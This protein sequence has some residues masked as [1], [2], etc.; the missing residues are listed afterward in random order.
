[1]K[2]A[3][4]PGSF[5]PITVGHV[6]IVKRGLEIFD[7]VVVALGNNSSKKYLFTSEQRLQWLHQVFADEKRVEVGYFEGL[8]VD[9]C[10]EIGAN[11]L[12][13]GLRN[14]SDFDY[15]KTISQI[16]NVVGEGIETVFFISQPTYSHISS[17]IVREVYKGKG[18]I[19]PFI[20]AEI[21]IK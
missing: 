13:R 17:T 5:D 3:V 8:T 21:T 18:D 9:Y 19:S 14:A 7:K 12:I 20:P 2:T 16:N 6:D 15:E 10:K 4:F 1:M 11:F